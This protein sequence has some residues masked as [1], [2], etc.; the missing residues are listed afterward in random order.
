[1]MTSAR[2]SRSCLPLIVITT[3]GALVAHALPG[4]QP[5]L[6]T[7]TWT[8]AL[9]EAAVE[10]EL[11]NGC[12]HLV[13]LIE[14]GSA[15]AV[16]AVDRLRAAVQAPALGPAIHAMAHRGLALAYRTGNGVAVDPAAAAMH[17][18]RSGEVDLVLRDQRLARR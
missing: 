6:P 4:R 15:D 18:D 10:L 14:G 16:W 1:M 13:G 5:G 3:L 9:G 17:E 12:Q 11:R 2:L 8:P 7:V